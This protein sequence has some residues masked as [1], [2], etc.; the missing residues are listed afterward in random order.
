MTARALV[1]EA[2]A[3][4]SGVAE[5][6][7]E[8]HWEGQE[9][10]LVMGTWAAETEAVARAAA[11]ATAKAVQQAMAG[12]AVAARWVAAAGGFPACSSQCSCIRQIR[13]SGK[14]GCHR[15]SRSSVCG[16]H[17]R[18]HPVAGRQVVAR[19][20]QAANDYRPADR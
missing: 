17:W 16:T 10:M 7:V 4:P 14:S 18:T 6:L 12:P 13:D 5:E 3:V 11:A 9:G 1:V 20:A 2:V 8:A 19:R 15:R